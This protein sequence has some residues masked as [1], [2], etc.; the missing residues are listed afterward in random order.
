MLP[1]FYYFGACTML[2][3]P[4]FVVR[5]ACL[6]LWLRKLAFSSTHEPTGASYIFLL[7]IS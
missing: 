4:S 5:Q 2:L 6:V 1:L 3:L 7:I